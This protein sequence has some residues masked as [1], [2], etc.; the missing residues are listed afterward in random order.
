MDTG[1]KVIYLT[2]LTAFFAIHFSLRWGALKRE[3]RDGRYRPGYALFHWLRLLPMGTASLAFGLALSRRAEPGG[4]FFLSLGALIVASSLYLG[5]DSKWA[6]RPRDQVR[7]PSVITHRRWIFPVAFAGL[8]VI[9]TSI[10]AGLDWAGLIFVPK[11]WYLAAVSMIVVGGGYAVVYR[12]A[13]HF[14]T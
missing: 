4:W 9:V 10:L 12:L 13:D 1:L 8:G 2:A 3:A 5:F 14:K 11:Q 6:L 7:A